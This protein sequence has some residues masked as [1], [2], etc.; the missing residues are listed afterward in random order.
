MK[1]ADAARELGI[2]E[3]SLCRAL[4]RLKNSGRVKRVGCKRFGYWKVCEE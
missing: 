4:E 2:G 3:R 1:I